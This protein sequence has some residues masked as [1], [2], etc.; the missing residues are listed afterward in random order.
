MED[1]AI[2][3]LAA[4][5]RFRLTDEEREAVKRELLYV[6]KMVAVYEEIDTA[7]AEEMILPFDDMTACLR[8]DIPGEVL[9]REEVLADTKKS[10]D[11]MAQIAKVVRE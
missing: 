2:D 4:D 11:G 8:E 9:K 6:E 3:R 10:R 5:V 7:E 1:K